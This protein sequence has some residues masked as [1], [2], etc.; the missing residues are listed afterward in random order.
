MG[1]LVLNQF[2]G[3]SSEVKLDP[4]TSI[5]ELKKLI[6]EG[7]PQFVAGKLKLIFSGRIL[8]DDMVIGDVDFQPDRFVVVL[9]CGATSTI[10][11]SAAKVR[12]A[13]VP[14]SEV[15]EIVDERSLESCARGKATSVPSV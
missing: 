15:S 10:L 1:E 11:A 9:L 6:A 13:T 3:H 14:S 12:M 8:S 4:R 2:N 5:G 7:R